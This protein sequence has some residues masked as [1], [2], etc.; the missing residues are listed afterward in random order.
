MAW[1]RRKEARVLTRSYALPYIDT[2]SLDIP[3]GALRVHWPVD[4]GVPHAGSVA[5][6]AGH[7]EDV[8]R[9]GGRKLRGE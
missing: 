9:G 1:L 2:L 8:E 3:D 7:G 6:E 5:H 4:V